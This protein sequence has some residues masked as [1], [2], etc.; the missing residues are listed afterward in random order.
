MK[1]LKDEEDLNIHSGCC[2]WTRLRARLRSVSSG[3][4]FLPAAL[5]IGAKDLQC[6]IKVTVDARR[7]DEKGPVGCKGDVVE[8]S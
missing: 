3:P 5:S 6:E 4:A 2:T 8:E 1:L 7:V